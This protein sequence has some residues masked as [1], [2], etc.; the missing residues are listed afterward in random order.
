MLK[1]KATKIVHFQKIL[2]RRRKIWNNKARAEKNKVRLKLE[3]GKI[4]IL[5]KLNTV[6]DFPFPG[7]VIIM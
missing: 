2:R 4:Q 3:I 6:Q 7:R 5:A 1:E